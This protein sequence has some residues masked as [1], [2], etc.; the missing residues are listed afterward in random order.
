MTSQLSGTILKRADVFANLHVKLGA[1][2]AVAL[3]DEQALL[4]TEAQARLLPEI[5]ATLRKCSLTATQTEVS[6]LLDEVFSDLTCSLYLSACALDVPARMLLR[7]SLEIGVATLYL[8]DH[9]QTFWAWREHDEDLSFN[10][11]LECVGSLKYRTFVHKENPF[12]DQTEIICSTQCNRL[13]RRLSNV[14]HGKMS[15]FESLDPDRFTH[16]VADWTC[17]LA[18]VQAVA[19]IVIIAWSKRSSMISD[20]IKGA[21]K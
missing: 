2:L 14:M 5:G 3:A 19:S 17:G 21:S 15:S 11:M 16:T 18:D 6:G 9:P 8:W 7:R 13:Y 12:Y 20:L 4:A 10:D 1:N